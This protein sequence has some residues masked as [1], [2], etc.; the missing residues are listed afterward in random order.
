MAA[1]DVSD[2]AEWLAG[3]LGDD[4]ELTALI[5]QGRVFPLFV[6][7]VSN[8]PAVTYKRASTQ[9][10]YHSTGQAESVV[11]MFEVR[12][13]SESN[14]QGYKTNCRVA[15]VLLG[16]L[17]GIRTETND[18]QGG[19]HKIESLEIVDEADDDDPSAVADG[20]D[21]LQRIFMV[22]VKYDEPPR[23]N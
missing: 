16:L 1:D 8:L 12:A 19:Q 18:S 3:R 11:G 20:A 22:Q 6:P 15:R 9:R 10:E 17:S 5:G 14:R 21:S 13:V 7:T 4:A 23:G 2:I